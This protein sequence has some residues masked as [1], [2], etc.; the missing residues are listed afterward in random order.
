MSAEQ[1]ESVARCCRELGAENAHLRREVAALRAKSE[2]QD[3]AL[4]S[5][6]RQIHELREAAGGRP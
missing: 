2:V 4:A 5:A 6:L 3:Q 1:I